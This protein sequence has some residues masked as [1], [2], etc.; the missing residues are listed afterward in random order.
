VSTPAPPS[1]AIGPLA[2]MDRAARMALVRASLDS[3]GCDALIVTKPEN[4]RWLTGF[5]GSNGLVV[6]TADSVTVV[7]DGRYQA[8]LAQQLDEAGVDAQVSITREIRRPVLAAASGADRIGLESAEVSWA[9]QRRFAEWFQPRD[10]V[11]TVDLIEAHRRIKDEGEIDRLRAAAAIADD[12]L[13]LLKPE[14]S[15]HRSE[16]W[17]ARNL[18]ATMLELGADDL[19]FDTIVAAGTNSARPH[20]TPCERVLQDG[21]MVVMDFGAKVDGYGSDMTRS[22]LLGQPS[23]RQRA[24]FDAVIEAQAAGVAAVRAG[25]EERE[26]DRICRSTLEQH[27]LADAFV[28]GTGHG[29]GLEIHENPILSTRASGILRSGYVVTVEPGVYLPDLGGVRIE[30]SV[31]VT[32]SGCEPITLSSKSPAVGADGSR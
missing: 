12:A 32:E 30:D 22:F 28:H 20:A 4:I 14:L 11:P 7:T 18:D 31:V 8:Q 25:I 9:D 21:D 15:N 2:P 27:G 5:T 3:A 23:D 29:I 16:R 19:S 26:I 17:I 10:L 13:T 1:F 24:V 6:L